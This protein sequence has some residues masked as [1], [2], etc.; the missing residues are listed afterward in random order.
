MPDAA[1]TFAVRTVDAVAR[2]DRAVWDRCAGAGNPFVS[3]EFLNALEESGSV[4]ARAGWLPQHAVLEDGAGAILGVAPMYLKNHSQGEYVFDWGW[5]DAY[6]RAGGRYY[7]K[8]IVAVPFT[9]V[10]GPRLLVPPGPR[11]AELQRV[12]IGALVRIAGKLGVTNLHITFPTAEEAALADEVGLLQRRAFQYHWHNRDYGSFDDFL[13]AL[14]SRKRK[15]IRKERAAVADAG[16]EVR[17]LTGGDLRSDHWDTFH[18][19]YTD[20]YDRKW[21][22]PYLTRRFFRLLH[23]RM[24][25]RVLLVWASADG[26]PVAGALNFIGEDALYGRNWGCAAD[27]RFLHFET[28][29]YRAIDFAIAHGLHRVE[30]GTQGPHKVQRGYLPVE[31]WSAHWIADDRFRSAVADF[32]D[33]E[34][35]AIRHE[36][37]IMAR[38]APYRQADGPA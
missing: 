4:G 8:L 14:A 34:S 1:E 21:G 24:A 16:I 6:E 5:A 30:A 32:L 38:H 36:M 20:T 37:A 2:L 3:W 18:R 31:T 35:A 22:Y 11:R 27:I 9:P 15:A 28:C 29:Y 7:P 25:D 26:A 19:F 12:L 13:A 10:T 33:R 17:A 23:E